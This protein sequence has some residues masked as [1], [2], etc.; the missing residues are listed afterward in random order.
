MSLETISGS[1]EPTLL[2]P[3]AP[4]E[5]EFEQAEFQRLTAGK[6]LAQ[7]E[8]LAIIST[9]RECKGNKAASARVL[10]ISEKSIYNKMRRLKISNEDI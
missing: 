10:G 9:L 6:T 5:E 2:F 4:N 1:L 3:T 7:I 8:R